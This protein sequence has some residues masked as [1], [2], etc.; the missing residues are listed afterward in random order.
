M[1]A[2][3]KYGL[4][5]HP[6]FFLLFPGF[7]AIILFGHIFYRMD[8]DALEKY[9]ETR[10]GKV[11]SNHE[12]I[13][14]LQAKSFKLGYF[15]FYC[16]YLYQWIRNLFKYSLN[17]YTAYNNIAFEREAY[18]NQTNFNYNETHWRNYLDK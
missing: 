2:I 1:A 5:H 4:K 7:K 3:E 15:S 16:R 13:H 12:R 6:N 11:T 17:G 9:L 8:K 14:V 18:K 10:S